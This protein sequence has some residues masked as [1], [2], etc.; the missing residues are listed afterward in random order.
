MKKVRA[1]YENRDRVIKLIAKNAKKIPQQDMAYIC[2]LSSMLE[3]ITDI[4][5]SRM[6]LEY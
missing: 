1:I 4:T 6:S 5:D 3:L 2:T